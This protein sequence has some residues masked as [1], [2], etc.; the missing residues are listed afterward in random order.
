VQ[1]LNGRHKHRG[2]HFSHPVEQ[3]TVHE[4]QCFEAQTKQRHRRA[5]HALR[6]GSKSSEGGHKEI[7]E[8]GGGGEKKRLDEIL[9]GFVDST[10]RQQNRTTAVASQDRSEGKSARVSVRSWCAAQC[11]L[12]GGVVRSSSPSAARYDALHWRQAR[13]DA[14]TLDASAWRAV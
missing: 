2:G 12:K 14:L 11:A 6:S 7:S 3:A 10:G 9:S 8:A 13:A 4:A 5:S 1:R